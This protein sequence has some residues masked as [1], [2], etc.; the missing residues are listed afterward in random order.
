MY[1]YMYIYYAGERCGA[2]LKGTGDM[3]I[4][5]YVWLYIYISS[6]QAYLSQDGE[7]DRRVEEGSQRTQRVHL[8]QG[9]GIGKGDGGGH[10]KP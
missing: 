4:S 5:V 1:I 7:E 3:I 2:E 8:I 10:D 9:G 6:T